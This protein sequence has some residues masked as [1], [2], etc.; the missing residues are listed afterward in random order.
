MNEGLQELQDAIEAMRHRT[1]DDSHIATVENLFRRA[2]YHIAHRTAGI[3]LLDERGFVR[4]AAILGGELVD[5]D[6]AYDPPALHTA[7]LW[8]AP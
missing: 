5:L 6:P 1:T 2:V 4:A 7:P 3:G 8:S